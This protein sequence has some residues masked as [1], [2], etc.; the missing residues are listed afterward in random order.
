MKRIFALVLSLLLVC[1]LFAGC[2]DSGL[3]YDYDINDYITVKEYSNIIDPESE[4]YIY[5]ADSFFEQSFG[6]NLNTKLTEG[7]VQ[8]GDIANIDYVGKLDG[9]AFDG[10]TATGYDLEIGSGQFIDGFEDGLIGVEIGTSVNLDLTFP[11]GYQ[12]T[13]LAGKAVV[14]EVKVNSVTRKGEPTEDNVKRY[15]FASLDDYKD[16]QA[17]YAASVSLFKNIYDAVT[18]NSHPKKESNL[19]YNYLLKYYEEVCAKN[20]MTIADLATANSMTEDQLYDYLLEYEVHGEV[21]FY[22]VAYYILQ[23]NGVELTTEDVEAK[24]KELD[25]EYE[26]PLEDIGYYEINIQQVAAYDK[27]LEILEQQYEIKK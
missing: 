26:Q 17:K 15:G 8:T 3:Y 14:F 24:R 23:V 22:M 6:E 21:E 12:S 16:K 18:F 27:A 10:G 11:E 25:E 19:H 5:A 7:T 1:T 2:G 13:E 20:N 4:D 9:V